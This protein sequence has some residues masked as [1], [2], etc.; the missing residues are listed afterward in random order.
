MLSDVFKDVLRWDLGLSETL[1][2]KWNFVYLILMSQGVN[3]ALADREL[4]ERTLN[5]FARA[6]TAWHVN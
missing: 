3:D 5:L 2:Q 4:D 6:D 1:S